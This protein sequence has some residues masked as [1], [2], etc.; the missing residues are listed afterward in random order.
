[1]LRSHA[2]WCE[3]GE[4]STKYFLSLEK[5][6]YKN[7]RIDKLVV[8]NTILTDI[9]VMLEEEKTYYQN[10]Y[11]SSEIN[12]TKNELFFFNNLNIPRISDQE[13]KKCEGEIKD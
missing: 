1:M 11:K 5:R 8:N 7:K 3:D 2:K 10:L 6:N 4:K 13:T 12:V 9:K